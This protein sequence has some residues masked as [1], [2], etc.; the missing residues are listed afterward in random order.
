MKIAFLFALAVGA[1]VEFPAQAQSVRPL[2]PPG[3]TP[4]PPIAVSTNAPAAR[5]AAFKAH[6]NRIER[7][8]GQITGE[9]SELRKYIEE[10]KKRRLAVPVQEQR[11]KQIV[12]L[13]PKLEKQLSDV[14]FQIQKIEVEHPEVWRRQSAGGTKTGR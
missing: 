14:R 9:A 6:K 12:A 2:N 11:L 5:Y 10:S 3:G 1:C 8:I 13:K 7:E 4:L